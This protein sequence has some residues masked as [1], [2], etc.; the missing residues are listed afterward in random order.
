[1]DVYMYNEKTDVYAKVQ[2]SN[3]NE[4]LG[5]VEYIFSDKTGTLTCNIMRFKCMSIGEYSYG[6]NSS[7]IMMP[8]VKNVNLTNSLV[9]NVDFSDGMF[10]EHM[11]NPEHE[12]A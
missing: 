6:D 4:E 1:M 12:N 10:Y 9:T 8:D 3:L 11:F 5:Q 2:S 7:K